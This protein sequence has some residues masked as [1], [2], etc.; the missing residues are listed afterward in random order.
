MTPARPLAASVLALGF[1]SSLTAP[2]PAFA[3]P[4]PCERAEN[5]AAQSGAEM[6]R[7]DRLELHPTK[8][9]GRPTARASPS[10]SSG[11]PQESAKVT[12]S[13]DA[14]LGPDAGLTGGDAGDGGRGAT[15]F[16]SG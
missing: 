15:G 1:A 6:L 2:L 4:A 11:S 7:I 9:P 16:L 14:L 12:N 13:T 3:A 5:Y 8:D 10:S